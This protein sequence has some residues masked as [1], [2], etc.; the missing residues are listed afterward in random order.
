MLKK[1]FAVLL[2]MGLLTMLPAGA[3]AQEPSSPS[4][5]AAHKKG[6]EHHPKIRHAIK[7]LEAARDDLQDASHDFGGHRAEALEAVNNAI[8]QLQEALQYDKK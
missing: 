5:P 7:A 6:G 3:M 1:L 8:K 4:Q 2:M